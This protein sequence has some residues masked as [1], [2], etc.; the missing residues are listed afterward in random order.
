M[1]GLKVVHVTLALFG[2]GGVFGGGERYAYE[3][4]RHMADQTPTRLVTFA[5]VPARRDVGR[6]DVRL[7]GRAWLLTVDSF[8][9]LRMGP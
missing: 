6:L 5:D 1:S 8:G 2:E 3:L 4:A 9:W 7:P